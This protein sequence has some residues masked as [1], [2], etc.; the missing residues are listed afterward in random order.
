MKPFNQEGEQ[1]ISHVQG[2]RWKEGTTNKFLAAIGTQ[3]G[4]F[5]WFANGSLAGLLQVM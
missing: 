5:E 3:R 4:C 1:G 2:F